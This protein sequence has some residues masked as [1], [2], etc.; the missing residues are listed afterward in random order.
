[1][2]TSS[3]DATSTTTLVT[4]LLDELRQ[5]LEPKLSHMLADYQLFK[6]THEAVLQIP[7]VKS[8]L[9]KQM[10]CKCHLTEEPIQLEIIDVSPKDEPNLDSIVEFINSV[11]E[12]EEEEQEEEEE[13]EQVQEEEEEEQVQEEEEEEQV[14]EEEE[15]EEEEQTAEKKEPAESDEAEEQD[16]PADEEEEEEQKEEEEEEEQKEDEEEQIAEKKEPAESDEAEEQDEELEL[17]EVDIKGKIYVTND[18]TNGDIYEY[19]N[20]EVGEVVGT[21]KNGVAKMMKKSKSNSKK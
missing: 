11:Q 19:E 6:E 14:Q 9:E 21:F 20:D 17:F 4:L 10:A 5:S 2:T 1:M 3:T 7:F 15:E 16:E 18:E 12:E 8:L 13:E